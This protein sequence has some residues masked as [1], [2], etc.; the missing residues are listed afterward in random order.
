VSAC[1]VSNTGKLKAALKKIEKRKAKSA[2]KWGDRLAAVEDAEKLK[3]QKREGTFCRMCF[4]SAFC[5]R[6][7]R[8]VR[9]VCYVWHSPPR[10]SCY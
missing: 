1:V 4:V 5:V 7:V 6:C 10:T 2:E 9:V 8:A 3:I